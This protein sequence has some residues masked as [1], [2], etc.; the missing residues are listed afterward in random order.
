VFYPE[1][2]EERCTAAL[3]L[4]VDP[5]GLVRKRKGASRGGFSLEQ[6]VNDRPFVASSF[7]SVAI[8]RVYG[9]ALA[10]TCKDRPDLPAEPLPL[11]ASMAVVPSRGGER[12]IPR[13]FEPLGYEVEAVRHTLDARFP[14]WGDS[15]Y[16]TLR[17]RAERP[18]AE[19]L[20]HVYVLVPVLDDVKHYWVGR[21]ELEKLLR[22]GEGWLREHPERDLIV[23]RYLRHQRRLTREA[24]A[25]LV[26]E[27]EQDPDA[28]AAAHAHEEE[29]LEEPIS[30]NEQRQ[31]AV[32]A[33]LR[34]SGA[35]RV[36]DLGCGE[37]RL[38][39]LLLK[40]KQFE[41]IVGL[42]VSHR[43][44]ESAHE[45]LKLDRLPPARRER[46]KLLHGSLMYRDDRIGG[47]DAAAVVEVIEHLDEARLAAFERVVFEFAQPSTVVVTTPNAEY[48]VRFE[49]VADGGLR[50]K[51][52]R[53]EWTR[54]EFRQWAGRVAERFG[55]MVRFGAVG[56]EDPEVGAPT[57]M[58][59][60]G[61]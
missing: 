58:G 36:L 21:D 10:G 55:Y 5:V 23:D 25:R 22:R 54:A 43:S 11:E 17:L 53:F 49:N 57:Q 52:H 41:E 18:L 60:F 37:G 15:P 4:D 44:L 51:D 26:E 61:R 13:L 27:E 19:L 59:V 31:A 7:L 8:A 56:P 3:L 35:Q 33:A 16:Y 32:I 12:L 28:T 50:H 34:D 39:A 40:E 46:I 30:L 20:A 14:E 24:L 47:Y 29:A 42:D 48:N 45:R 9:T 1:A 38:L 6:Y 2:S